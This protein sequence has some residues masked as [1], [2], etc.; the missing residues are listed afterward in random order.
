MDSAVDV[1]ITVSPVQQGPSIHQLNSHQQL[2]T[3]NVRPGNVKKRDSPMQVQYM[4]VLMS[5]IN[6][7]RPLHWFAS[8]QYSTM[9]VWPCLLVRSIWSTL[10]V[11][12]LKTYSKSKTQTLQLQDES[13]TNPRALLRIYSH[14]IAKYSFQQRMIYSLMMLNG[15]KFGI[16]KTVL[17]Q[18]KIVVQEEVDFK[19]P[20]R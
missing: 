8:H 14:L 7:R 6:F 1:L 12:Q 10:Y 4:I 15:R 20:S 19:V 11:K 13:I 18:S 5:F 9:Y 2:Q 16:Y 17:L 3:H